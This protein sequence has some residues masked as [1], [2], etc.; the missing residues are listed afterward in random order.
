MLSDELLRVNDLT[1]YFFTDQGIVPSVDGINFTVQ[2]GQTL[3][4]VG[5]SGSGK[6][7]TALSLMGLIPPPGKVVQ[8]NIF[9][10]KHDL[11]KLK[12]KAFRKIRGNE[13]AMIFQEPMTSLNPVYTIGNQ[14][15]EAIQLHMRFSHENARKRALTMLNRVGIPSPETRINAYPHQLSGGMK[16]RIMIA[17]ALSCN[18]DLLIA[19]EPTTALDVTIQAQILELL[20]DLQTELDMGIILITHDLG[21]IAE[22]ADYVLVMYAGRVMEKADVYTLFREPKHPYTHGLFKSIPKIDGPRGARLETIQGMVPSPLFF[23]TGCRFRTRCPYARVHCAASVPKLELVG[24]NHFSACHFTKQ[25]AS[26]T[27]KKQIPYHD[28][29]TIRKIVTEENTITEII[30]AR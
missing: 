8:G 10:K 13:V 20:R 18:P 6:S 28:G 23:P 21:V 26:N 1:T 22:V 14:L 7:V 15:I 29:R 24:E 2:K 17:M 4:I 25:I 12:Q 30:N 19:D 3:G 9:F 11:L 16:Q 27:H 5:E